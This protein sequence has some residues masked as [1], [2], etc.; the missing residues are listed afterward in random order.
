MCVGRLCASPLGT[1]GQSSILADLD[2][3]VL[4]PDASSKA[5]ENGNDSETHVSKNREKGGLKVCSGKDRG[6]FWSR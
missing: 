4:G 1:V 6:F 3:D 5:Q 2:G